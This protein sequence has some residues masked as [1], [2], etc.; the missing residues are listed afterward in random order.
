M[1]ITF[2]GGAR[3]VTGSMHLVET[4]GGSVLLECGMFQGP[5]EEANQRNRFL[6]AVAK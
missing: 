4:E 2:L 3:T 6:P 5:R 1:R